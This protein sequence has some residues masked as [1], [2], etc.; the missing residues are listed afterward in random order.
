MIKKVLF[1][2]KKMSGSSDIDGQSFWENFLE[3][4]KN[5]CLKMS[6]DKRADSFLHKNVE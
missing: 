4:G 1:I 6:L 2:Q 5:K 3:V